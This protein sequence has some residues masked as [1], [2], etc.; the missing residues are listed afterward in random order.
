MP[1]LSPQSQ[2]PDFF[3]DHPTHISSL[4]IIPFPNGI[5]HYTE[6][7]GWKTPLDWYLGS[8]QPLYF[9]ILYPDS[10]VHGFKI[11]VKPDL[12]DTSLHAINISADDHHYIG[13]NNVF[14]QPYNICGDTLVACW[15]SGSPRQQCGVYTG[16]TSSRF[17]NVTSHGG[18]AAK[19]LLPATGHMFSLCPAS[20][21]FVHLNHDSS[22][23]LVDDFF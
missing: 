9:D 15:N 11:I 2:P 23:I 5:L 12:Y 20:G 19:M 4:F 1:P 21:K 16:L 17:S 3:D 14:L 7:A 13:D 10:K 6:I 18:P 22:R 8:S